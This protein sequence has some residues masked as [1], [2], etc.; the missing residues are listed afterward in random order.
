MNTFRFRN[1]AQAQE[2]RKGDSLIP[3]G[4]FICKLRL[5]NTT[6]AIHLYAGI[7]IKFLYFSA[8]G[9]GLELGFGLAAQLSLSQSLKPKFSVEKY[10]NL[11][12]ILTPF[13]PK[14]SDGRIVNSKVGSVSNNY[15]NLQFSSVRIS[16]NFQI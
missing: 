1:V 7:Y 8:L 12:A 16:N 3:R 2:C 14:L 10:R 15:S 13:K 11:D 4:S 6:K 9:L 5:R